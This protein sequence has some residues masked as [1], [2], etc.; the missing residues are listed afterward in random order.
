MLF[1]RHG[2]GC[3]SLKVGGTEI[4]VDPF[5]SRRE[6][7]GDWYLPNLHAPTL[8]EYFLHHCPDYV[9]IT[10]GHFDHFD[11]EAVKRL[12]GA[13]SPTFLGSREVVATLQR[14]FNPPE[15]KLVTVEPGRPVRLEAMVLEAR[16]GLHWLTG[17]EASR[18]AEK[19]AQRPDRYG[20]LPC[21]GPML[22]FILASPEGRIYVSG[23][24]EPTGVPAEMVDV[25]IL[26]LGEATLHPS[27]KEKAYP[28]LRPSQAAQVI[29]DL[30][31]PR[32]VIPIHYEFEV[33][34]EPTDIEAFRSEVEQSP[35]YPRVIVAP[36][37]QWIE[38][39]W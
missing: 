12:M 34:V 11:L 15:D 25:A 36:F 31:R 24:T 33:F 5:F 35:P 8:G 26:N 30:L 6:D 20:V 2:G 39:T 19:L 17:E 1:C 3:F 16:E 29:R 7:Y 32:V 38:V 21:G 4:L 10:H 13:L 28:T 27:T 18:T 23:D 9:F 37:N 22:G 14:Y